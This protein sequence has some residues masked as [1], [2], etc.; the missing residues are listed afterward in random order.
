MRPHLTFLYNA[1]APDSSLLHKS[2]LG[3]TASEPYIAPDATTSLTWAALPTVK[4]PPKGPWNPRCAIRAI[5][6][7][8]H[9]HTVQKDR[10][11]SGF[12]KIQQIV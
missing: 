2:I 6:L 3:S 10:E 5:H 9:M 7:L 1:G 12:T 8:G 11:R 4:E